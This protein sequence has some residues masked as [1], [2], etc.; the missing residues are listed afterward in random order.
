M[1]SIGLCRVRVGS[2]K[3]QCLENQTSTCVVQAATPGRVELDPEGS[4]NVEASVRGGLG[5]LAVGRQREVVA[6][7]GDGADAG[8]DGRPGVALVLAQENLAVRG[9]GEERG[10]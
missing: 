3:C 5:E 2:G 10:A 1:N 8:G 7:L 6:A 9:A 4:L